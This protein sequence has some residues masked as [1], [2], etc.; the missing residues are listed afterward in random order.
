MKIKTT[1][2]SRVEKTGTQFSVK[3]ITGDMITSN[4]IFRNKVMVL[5]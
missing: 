1:S 4:C 3:G 2:R 5:D